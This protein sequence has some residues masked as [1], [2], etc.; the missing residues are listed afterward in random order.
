MVSRI[1]EH[2]PQQLIDLRRDHPVLH[3]KKML[4]G[5]AQ[6]LF[7]KAP[8]GS[9]Q[10]NED[11]KIT[12]LFVL[13]GTPTDTTTYNAHPIITVTLSGFQWTSIGMGDMETY[14]FRSGKETKASLVAGVARYNCSSRNETEASQLGWVLAEHAWLLRRFMLRRGFYDFGRQPQQSAPTRG[15][16]VL[17]GAGHDAWHTVFV[18]LP[19]QI[20]R[21]SSFYPL[22]EQIVSSIEHRMS[23][24]TSPIQ[25]LDTP[26]GVSIEGTRPP[27]YSN[28]GDAYGGTPNPGVDGPP[29]LQRMPHPFNPAQTI[30][31]RVVRGRR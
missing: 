15:A 28:A 9:F 30:S 2:T 26:V 4:V 10:W 3:L 17:V 8:R 7:G 23:V 25:S 5:F 22:N 27:P 16:D 13:D 1:T 18:S 6:G 29:L 31:I 21:T 14:D 24:V 12:E 19:F 11:P 20:S